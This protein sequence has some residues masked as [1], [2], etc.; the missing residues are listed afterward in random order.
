MM[1]WLSHSRLNSVSPWS[2]VHCHGMML[3]LTKGKL[4]YRSP[5][6][7]NGPHAIWT[8]ENENISG[9]LRQASSAHWCPF[10][11]EECQR[12]KRSRNDGSAACVEEPREEDEKKSPPD[13]VYNTA[14]AGGAHCS[15]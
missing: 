8:K 2:K 12:W 14:Y 3:G 15:L 11:L 7:L 9:W 6:L 1:I 10:T 4:L 13:N 5:M